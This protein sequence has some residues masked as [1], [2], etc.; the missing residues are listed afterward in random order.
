MPVK[1]TSLN[2]KKYL[3][4]SI[5]SLGLAGQEI[6]L[7]SNEFL[8]QIKE[9]NRDQEF[10]RLEE[11]VIQDSLQREQYE[12]SEYFGFDYFRYDSN[13]KTPILD[14]P[15]PSDYVI[16]FNDELE[17]LI[18]GSERLF[19]KSRVG[20]NGDANFERLGSINLARLP[21]SIANEKINSLI[22]DY[23]VGA[24]GFLQVSKPS[25]KKISIIGAVKE[26]GTYVVNPYISLSEIIKYAGG[27]EEYSSLRNIEIK[28]N[29]HKSKVV[30]LYD[31][32]VFG[33]IDS[34][35][36]LNHGDTVLINSAEGFYRISGAINRPMFYEFKSGDRLD[37]IIQF[38]LGAKPDADLDAIVINIVDE[39][40]VITKTLTVEDSVKN[41]IKSIYVPYKEITEDKKLI[42]KG[43]SGVD[44]VYEYLEGDKLS[45][46]IKDLSFSN[47]IYPFYFT[48]SQTSENGQ[49][50]EF[51]ELN[52]FD[53]PS[54]DIT[55]KKNVEINFF[56]RAIIDEFSDFS[57][58]K[59]LLL[60]KIDEENLSRAE[61]KELNEEINLLEEEWNSKKM[62]FDESKVS[63]FALLKFGNFSKE[64]PVA[65]SIDISKFI[66]YFPGVFS[67]DVANADIILSEDY[68]SGLDQLVKVDAKDL[69][70]ISVP[71]YEINLIS[72]E[73]KGEVNYPGEYLLG[74]STTVS[75]LYDA[76]GGLTNRAYPYGA[77]FSRESV[78]SFERDELKKAK[79]EILD[80]VIGILG[81]PVKD[82][83]QIDTNVLQLLEADDA[84]FLG[85]ISGDFS[86]D[87]EL[88]K[89]MILEDGD[90]L[91]I[92]P[93]V[94]LVYVF[95]EVFQPNTQEFKSSKLSD[96]I[97]RAGGYSQYADKEN[98]YVIRA[99]GS[100]VSDIS[101]YRV[102]PGDMIVVPRDL[103]KV[104]G[105]P[106]V[107]VIS[108]VLS[109][110]A[111]AAA[112]INILNN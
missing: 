91:V 104:S 51:F 87:S 82:N 41:Q 105:L 68:I 60:S 26:P 3:L 36:N 101:G 107:T 43:D 61:E 112:S 40:N 14:I 33:N 45:N 102:N 49:T 42:V 99:N 62:N 29:N 81:N 78:K 12:K 64:L 35:I 19:L 98:V 72:V 75:A 57:T 84:E 6:D 88:S 110:L 111:L 80:S 46:F 67:F 5:L 18:T 85:R 66:R 7:P 9:N 27:L 106:L 2:Y 4:L 8:E 53:M 90:V 21:L 48:V 1:K 86:P 37:E 31:F 34:D 47:D 74:P 52:V 50:K 83:A 17:L 56:S 63:N 79:Q 96:Y 28:S 71:S 92:P 73:I 76:A 69:K 89:T 93:K 77:F 97:N 44:G 23:F 94:N 13:T 11:P 39:A 25:L 109:N 10:N 55:F 58:S 108:Q 15:L 38:S 54:S 65:G 16:S 30:D 20:L 95:G 32:L 103:D 24:E 22:D 100:V 59:K 70:L